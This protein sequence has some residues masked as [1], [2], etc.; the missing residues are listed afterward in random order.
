[1]PETKPPAS[2]NS[3]LMSAFTQYLDG[4]IH[5]NDPT[6]A[7]DN[8]AVAAV[9]YNPTGASTGATTASGGFDTDTTGG[10]V[11][12]FVSISITQPSE[13]DL[14][15]GTGAIFADSQA[16]SGIGAQT[17][18]N[19]TGLTTGV[20]HYNHFMHVTVDGNSNILTSAG[21]TPVAITLT[22]LADVDF[23]GAEF[24]GGNVIPDSTYTGTYWDTF[25]EPSNPATL[26]IEDDLDFPSG[27]CIE[28]IV[29]ASITNGSQTV[30]FGG[31][32]TGASAAGLAAATYT[33]TITIDSVGYPVSITTT[34]TET[35]DQV[36]AA[37]NVDLPG[38]ECSLIGGDIVVT[39]PI[40]GTSSLVAITLDTLFSAM[41]NYVAINAAVAGADQWGILSGL[42]FNAPSL[43]LQD[44]YVEFKAK[45]QN[46][47]GACKF[48][49]V[50]GIN[51][52]QNYANFTMQLEWF[53]PQAPY[54]QTAFISRIGFGDG[55]G[56]ENDG[57]NVVEF[58]NTNPSWIGSRNY[59]YTVNDPNT[60]VTR[61]RNSNWVPVV[62]TVYDFK[63][64][65]RYNSG[66]T[67]LNEIADGI[68]SVEIDGVEAVTAS[69]MF[70]RHYTNGFLDKL[71]FFDWS[72]NN[73]TS[74][75]LRYSSFKVS[76]V[77]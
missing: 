24:I 39:S 75:T 73:P 60:S 61:T 72:Q 44:F 59:P 31:L 37:I 53:N 46:G 29:P 52:N 25:I 76:E 57:N 7:N 34:G 62:G 67:A 6:A 63:V 66:T 38:T 74:F 10:T 33:V 22:V 71:D 56:T 49:K 14:I 11:Y 69:N 16:G 58:V 9:I 8:V 21:F 64:R 28:S 55:A 40:Y 42:Y 35:V 13:A 12:R 15:T 48:F 41:T 26:T 65:I 43:A 27:K 17:F 30:N 1:M 23:T 54:P 4:S 18:P 19:S 32:L 51:G 45:F 70:N 2:M 20:V 36:I 50:G 47:L 68:I 77:G 3:P 5:S